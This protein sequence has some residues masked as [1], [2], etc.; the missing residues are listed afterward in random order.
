MY[1]WQ[2]MEYRS[3]IRNSVFLQTRIMNDH[4]CKERRYLEEEKER[5]Q[6]EEYF[7]RI[8]EID[9]KKPIENGIATRVALVCRLL[10]TGHE[11]LQIVP[12]VIL[13]LRKL[14]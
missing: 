2:V 6:K 14:F 1:T 9:K 13:N 12:V 8:K 4:F 5:S 7:N 10:S 11:R 3:F